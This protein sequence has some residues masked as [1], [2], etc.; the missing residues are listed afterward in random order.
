M[1]GICHT[2]RRYGIVPQVC[3]C[4]RKITSACVN[5]RSFLFYLVF[6]CMRKSLVCYGSL[7]YLVFDCVYLTAKQTVPNT[8]QTARVSGLV[9]CV[10][11]VLKN[12]RVLSIWVFY[13]RPKPV[14]K[15]TRVFY[16]CPKL[17]LKNTRVFYSCQF[18]AWVNN[19]DI[20]L[21]LRPHAASIILNRIDLAEGPT[22]AIQS[23]KPGPRREGI[24]THNGKEGP[25]KGR[26]CRP[27]PSS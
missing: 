17:V 7:L 25:N 18:S 27:V 14:L 20:Y 26:K 3:V 10:D 23:M 5:V 6:D 2:T 8:V 11:S 9:S 21:F 19:C 15:N 13:S 24:L 16:S 4:A 12:T 1:V 22:G